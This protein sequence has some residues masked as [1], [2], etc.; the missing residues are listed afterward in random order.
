[1]R[2]RTTGRLLVLVP[3]LLLAACTAA[4]D[5]DGDQPDDLSPAPAPGQRWQP[6]PGSAGSGS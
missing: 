5:E 1:M 2:R 6:R 4:P 3:L